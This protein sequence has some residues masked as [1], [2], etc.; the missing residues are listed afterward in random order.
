MISK[1]VY[2]NNVGHREDIIPPTSPKC[3]EI[4]PFKDLTYNTTLFLSLFH[5][6]EL[7]S[8]YFCPHHLERLIRYN[9]NTYSTQKVIEITAGWHH[10]LTLT[11][12]E[13]Y[14]SETDRD[15]EDQDQGVTLVTLLTTACRGRGLR[16]A[17]PGGLRVC[18]PGQVTMKE[19]E[20]K[21]KVKK[22]I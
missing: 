3:H 10:F 16:T 9:V 19:E 4:I 21:E 2:T 17:G 11:R 1:T 12:P 20:R 6:P 22:K 5:W 8:R 14:G 18:G 15:E 7:E 13:G